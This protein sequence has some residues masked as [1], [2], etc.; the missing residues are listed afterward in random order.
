MLC[1]GLLPH[2]ILCVCA[3]VRVCVRACVYVHI[4]VRDSFFFFCVVFFGRNAYQ[5]VL[6]KH[7]K[8]LYEGLK[9]VV[10]EHLEGEVG[11]DIM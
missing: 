3:C 7:G 6:H 9:S 5:M 8:K 4:R 11:G 2:C 10:T 1:L